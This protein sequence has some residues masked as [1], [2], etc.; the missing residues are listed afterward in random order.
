MV[1]KLFTADQ[2]Y[3]ISGMFFISK[4]GNAMTQAAKILAKETGQKTSE[5]VE[6]SGMNFKDTA[7][8][9]VCYS[10]SDVEENEQVSC[11]PKDP[12]RTF[13]GECNN[14]EVRGNFQKLPN[15]PKSPNFSKIYKFS[16]NAKISKNAKFPKVAK[17]SKITKYS[18]KAKMS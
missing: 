1:F 5:P 18:K 2:P 11:D 10:N 17:I 13:A 3:L 8:E 4:H 16:K 7:F 14:L 9:D 12:F 15:F 6:F